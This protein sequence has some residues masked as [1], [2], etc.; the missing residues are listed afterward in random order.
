ML[1]LIGSG[2]VASVQ[3]G[4][5]TISPPLLREDLAIDLAGLIG[6]IFGTLDATTNI[7]GTTIGWVGVRR[8]WHLWP[9]PGSPPRWSSGASPLSTSIGEKDIRP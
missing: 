7:G 8:S 5:A 9:S 3:I 2:V 4:K 6:A 1:L